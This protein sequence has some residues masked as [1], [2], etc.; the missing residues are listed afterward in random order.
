MARR[1]R[2]PPFQ[3]GQRVGW[4]RRIDDSY[5]EGEI[6][7]VLSVQATV[8]TDSGTLLFVMNE[9]EYKILEGSDARR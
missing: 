6:V 8:L 7:D 3:R 5:V 4:V 9:D 1:P 2:K